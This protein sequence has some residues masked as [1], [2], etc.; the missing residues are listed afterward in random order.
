MNQWKVGGFT[1]SG[2][3]YKRIFTLDDHANASVKAVF[4]AGMA[5]FC[6]FALAVMSVIAGHSADDV[7]LPKR[8]H[9]GFLWAVSS[10]AMLLILPLYL[11]R[12][13]RPPVVLEFHAAD[14]SVRSGGSIVTRFEKIE[15]FDRLQ[16]HDNDGQTLWRLSLVY[17]D[18]RE[19]P[20]HCSYDGIGL[21]ELAREMAE[22][23][24][25]SVRVRSEANV[26]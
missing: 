1:V 11:G 19:L 22:F 12:I 24:G 7:L 6:I 18:G 5:C 9:V 3:A 25:A 10:G 16:E 8:N 20:I 13:Y 21:G 15:F 4:F 26:T 14:R 23:S 17:G 2:D